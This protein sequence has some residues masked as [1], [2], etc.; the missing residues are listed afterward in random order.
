MTNQ[1]PLNAVSSNF[2]PR[3]GL[4][5]DPP[6]HQLG[7][8]KATTTLLASLTLTFCGPAA[9]E[10]LRLVENQDQTIYIETTSIKRIGHFRQL[11]QMND[12]KESAGDNNSSV[13]VLE[14]DCKEFLGRSLI[15]THYSG[16]LGTGRKTYENKDPTQWMPAVY[17]RAIVRYACSR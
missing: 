1:V 14:Y 8:M 11:L 9:A 10:W 3:V 7:L 16:N 12:L 4:V 13:G 15:S 2:R 6:T 17:V 5:Y